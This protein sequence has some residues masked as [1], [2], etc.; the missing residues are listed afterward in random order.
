MESLYLSEIKILM[1]TYVIFHPI[2]FYIYI[3]ARHLLPIFYFTF[4]AIELIIFVSN[5]FFK[6][7]MPGCESWLFILSFAESHPFFCFCF[8]P[9]TNAHRHQLLSGQFERVRPSHVRSQLHLQ[10][11]IHAERQLAVRY[12]LLLPKQFCVF[13]DGGSRGFHFD[14][15][16][17]R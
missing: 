13:G 11:H 14:G 12:V 2:L 5:E 17:L 7:I 16:F 10:F 9:S 6:G 1:T 4:S 15:H 8:S 3:F